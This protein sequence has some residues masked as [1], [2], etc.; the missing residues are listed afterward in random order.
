M[1]IE[2]PCV[3][4]FMCVYHNAKMMNISVVEYRYPE[5]ARRAI[6]TMNKAEFMGRPVFVREVIHVCHCENKCAYLFTEF[7]RIAN[8]NILG[9]QKILVMF[10]MIV[11]FTSAM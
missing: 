11:D 8:L 6:H 5:D 9:H 4:V 7:D 3:C 10:L 2:I 1:I